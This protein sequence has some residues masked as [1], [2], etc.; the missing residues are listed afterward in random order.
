MA[1]Q[2]QTPLKPFLLASILSPPPTLNSGHFSSDSRD[3]T[4]QD[5]SMRQSG[6]PF[7]PPGQPPPECNHSRGHLSGFRI[8]IQ[9]I[10]TTRVTLRLNSEDITHPISN[11][12]PI[13]SDRAQYLCALTPYQCVDRDVPPSR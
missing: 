3:G 12:P 9:P 13:E 5:S 4:R 6:G 1:A 11:Y 10:L 2:S 8:S 7:F